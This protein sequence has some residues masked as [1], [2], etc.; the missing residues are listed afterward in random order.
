MAI[1]KKAVAMYSFK[2]LKEELKDVSIPDVYSNDEFLALIDL[3]TK[4]SRK[5]IIELGNKFIKSIDKY[6]KEQER[7]LSMYGF[8]K[9]FGRYEIVAGVDEVG[10]GPLAG[11]IVSC[12]VVLDLNADIDGIILGI[13]DSKAL[14]KEKREEL[15][16]I[17]KEKALAYSS[18]RPSGLRKTTITL[19]SL[20][21][22]TTWLRSDLCGCI[23]LK[24]GYRWHNTWN[25][26]FQSFI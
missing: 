8:D 12:A 6:K 14:S 26:G 7:V 17:I 24:C 20:A 21:H 5:N 15:C 3:L 16:E 18:R 13:K 4:D 19:N 2:E 9:S 23:G 1:L 22:R 11:P 10:R 25:Q